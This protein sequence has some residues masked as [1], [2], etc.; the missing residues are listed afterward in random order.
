MGCDNVKGF[1]TDEMGDLNGNMCLPAPCGWTFRPLKRR[2]A[3]ERRRG[4][5]SLHGRVTDPPLSRS[6]RQSEM[7]GVYVHLTPDE[8]PAMRCRR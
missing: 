4:H 3:P 5:P 2:P 6:I 1:V 7:A 8:T